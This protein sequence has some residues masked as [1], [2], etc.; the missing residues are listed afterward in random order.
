MSDTRSNLYGRRSYDA[1]KFLNIDL[2]IDEPDVRKYAVT[3]T[4]LI[5]KDTDLT[6]FVGCVYCT[7]EQMKA[8]P[9]VTAYAIFD[10]DE[11]K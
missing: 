2:A 1:I 5:G 3:R 6:K 8:L 4:D 11:V 7:P 9:K 10:Y